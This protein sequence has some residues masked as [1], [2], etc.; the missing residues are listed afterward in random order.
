MLLRLA[1]KCE[2]RA[3][4]RPAFLRR[5]HA[6]AR[7]PEHDRH[8]HKDQAKKWAE[9]DQIFMRRYYDSLPLSTYADSSESPSSL[10][11]DQQTTALLRRASIVARKGLA[12]LMLKDIRAAA[13]VSG[14][15]L[16]VEQRLLCRR[17]MDAIN[18]A[19]QRQLIRYPRL[20]RSVRRACRSRD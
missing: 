19:A 14:D 17:A 8:S 11:P 9:Y 12:E 10:T 6:G 7:G 15:N 5:S 16:T 20:S 1:Y 18:P 4:P 13:E 3:V 2:G